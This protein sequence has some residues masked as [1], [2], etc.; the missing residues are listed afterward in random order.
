MRSLMFNRLFGPRVGVIHE[1]IPKHAFIT[2]HVTVH[3]TVTV[4]WIYDITGVRY[5]K[6]RK[7]HYIN[8]KLTVCNGW[9]NNVTEI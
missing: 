2:I 3:V 4:I 1:F 8:I 9:L 7:N 5:M 6:Y